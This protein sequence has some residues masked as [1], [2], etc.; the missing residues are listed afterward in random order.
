MTCRPLQGNECI[1]M[2]LLH[3]CRSQHQHID[4]PSLIDPSY[5]LHMSWR[6]QHGMIYVAR[7]RGSMRPCVRPSGWPHQ[8]RAMEMIRMRL[9]ELQGYIIDY[10]T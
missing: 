6:S 3:W 2:C 4:Y 8:V 9:P 5:K 1:G 10:W 7:L